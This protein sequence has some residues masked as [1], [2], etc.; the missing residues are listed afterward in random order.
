MIWNGNQV[1]R[2]LWR[3]AVR[4]KGK[5]KVNRR[6]VRPV[7]LVYFGD[8]ATLNDFKNSITLLVRSLTTD[9]LRSVVEHT[10]SR[11]EILQVDEDGHFKHLSLH[12]PGHD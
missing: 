4:M 2:T 8:V 11:L 5:V 1:M 10:V 12:R 7:A 6:W 3:S 9:Q